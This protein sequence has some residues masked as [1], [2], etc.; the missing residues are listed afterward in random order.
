[1]S[2]VR[3]AP[4][5]FCIYCFLA[6]VELTDEHIIPLGLNGNHILPASSC[7]RCA[8]I[9]SKIE[10]EML[11]GEMAQVR[12]AFA[13][14]T[15]RP[16]KVPRSF[17]LIITRNGLEEIIDAP[18]GDHLILLPLPIYPAPGF[19]KPYDFSKG[20]RRDGV[21]ILRFGSEPEKL[22][23]KYRA[24]KVGVEIRIEYLLRCAFERPQV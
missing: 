18:I 22:L 5:G 8:G 24:E 19:L 21:Q 14:K 6:D 13:F 23:K 20:I 11:R 15:R 7:K 3:Y 17:P 16:K 1:M 12:A 10:R 2:V 4:V 9:T